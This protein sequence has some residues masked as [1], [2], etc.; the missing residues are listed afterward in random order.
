MTFDAAVGCIQ[1]GRDVGWARGGDG[2]KLSHRE[3]TAT[4]PRA[5]VLDVRSHIRLAAHV[6]VVLLDTATALHPPVLR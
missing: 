2:E 6:T 4:T 3:L 5:L 1:V